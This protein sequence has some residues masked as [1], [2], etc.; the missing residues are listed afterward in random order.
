MRHVWIRR[1]NREKTVEYPIKSRQEVPASA[2]NMDQPGRAI[3]KGL[4]RFAT[5]KEAASPNHLSAS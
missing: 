1:V 4:N 5:D 3:S 2:L